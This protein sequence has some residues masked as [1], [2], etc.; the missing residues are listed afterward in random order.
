MGWSVGNFAGTRWPRPAGVGLL[1]SPSR[2]A[3]RS[4]SMP[5]VS[6]E[7]GGKYASG[8]HNASGRSRNAPLGEPGSVVVV[9]TGA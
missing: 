3:A 8:Y 4:A 7:Q 6:G 1:P 9:V 5:V 2:A